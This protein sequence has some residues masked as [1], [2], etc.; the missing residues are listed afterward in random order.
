MLYLHLGISNSVAIAGTTKAEDIARR[1]CKT[2]WSY[3]QQSQ[4]LGGII[5]VRGWI[6]TTMTTTEIFLR[7][8]MI[9]SPIY[10]NR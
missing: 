3:F 6:F 10:R 8:L 4:V 9:V 5:M 2:S 7:S 1:I